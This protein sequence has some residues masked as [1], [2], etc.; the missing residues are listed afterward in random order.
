MRVVG[1]YRSDSG[2]KGAPEHG[3][4]RLAKPYRPWHAYAPERFQHLRLLRHQRRNVLQATALCAEARV[5]LRHTKN[6]LQPYPGRTPACTHARAR[7]HAR[8]H[9]LAAAATIP[10]T[11]TKGRAAVMLHCNMVAR[12]SKSRWRRRLPAYL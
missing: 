8:T 2:P 12:C 1:A 6:A 4:R 9:A 5:D 7:A 11:V 10:R 3:G